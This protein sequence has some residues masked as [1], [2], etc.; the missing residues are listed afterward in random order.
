MGTF[1]TC[2]AVGDL[3][4]DGKPDL[5]VGNYG[6]SNASVRLGNGDGTFGSLSNYGVGSSPQAVALAD[7][8]GD[9][10]LDLAVANYSSNTVSLLLGTGIGTFGPASSIASGPAQSVT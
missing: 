8:N 10:K 9:A 2:A 5:V 1:P 4:G 7:Y 3:N 6:S